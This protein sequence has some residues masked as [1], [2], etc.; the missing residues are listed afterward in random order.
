MQFHPMSAY[1]GRREFRAGA[2]AIIAVTLAALIFAAGAVMTY[3]LRGWYWVSI[4][5]TCG[6]V[7]G[8]AGVIQTMALRVVLTDDALLVTDY[9]GRRRYLIG[10]IVRVEE[11][12]GT[13]TAILLKDG[14]WVKLPAVGTELGNS[15]R[16]WLKHRPH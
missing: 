8:L 7:L 16:A 5:L 15:I 14:R 3:R 11:A 10:D 1:Q 9:P 13:P 2:A 6:S 12:K 4:V